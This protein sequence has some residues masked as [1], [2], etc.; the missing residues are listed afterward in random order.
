MSVEHFP[1][2]SQLARVSRKAPTW[3]GVTEGFLGTSSSTWW[4][5]RTVC[6]LDPESLR[7]TG[8]VPVTVG[9]TRGRGPVTD[10]RGPNTP[11]GH[12]LKMKDPLQG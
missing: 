12:D 8:R 2:E 3:S 5:A 10:T 7:P 11:R 9:P 4:E 1:R 6:S